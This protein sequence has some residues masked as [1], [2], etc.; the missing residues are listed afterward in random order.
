MDRSPSVQD[1]NSKK[2]PSNNASP[3]GYN[4]SQL[5]YSQE[6]PSDPNGIFTKLFKIERK[7]DAVMNIDI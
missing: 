5:S 2:N 3:D 7:V 6:R 4:N 1:I